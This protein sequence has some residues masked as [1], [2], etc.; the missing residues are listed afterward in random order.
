MIEK[1]LAQ[2]YAADAGVDLDIVEREIVLTYV[3]RTIADRGLLSRLAFKGGTAIRKLFLGNQGR[4]S[5]DLDFTSVG[6]NNPDD[7]I[8]DVVEALVNE[9]HYGIEFTIPST[10]YYVAPD[11]CGADVTYR[12]DWTTNS[13]FGIQISLRAQPLLPIQS[14]PLRRE[15][16][17]DWLGMELPEIPTLDFHEILGEKIR[18]AAQRSRVRDVFDLYQLASHTFDRDQVRRIAVIKCWET[19]FAFEPDVFWQGLLSSRYDW[20]DLRRLVRRGRELTPEMIL[21][22]VRKDYA[23]LNN[24]SPEE[25]ILAADPY[26]RQQQVYQQLIDQLHEM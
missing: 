26:R 4:F 10:D 12:H 17:F 15:R 9:P 19:R 11:S 8:L 6:E 22:G 25:A 1:R 16:Y 20:S 14:M 7:L 5:L 18:A 21:N 23:F 3:L 24:F 2:W 13:R